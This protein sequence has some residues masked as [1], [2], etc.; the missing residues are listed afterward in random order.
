VDCRHSKWRSGPAQPTTLHRADAWQSSG[1]ISTEMKL[2]DGKFAYA[3]PAANLGE[4][5]F[6]DTPLSP[7][8]IKRESAAA[9]KWENQLRQGVRGSNE[10]GEA[11]FLPSR[12]SDPR[13]NS[14]HGGAKAPMPE[15]Q[16][17]ESQ[18]KESRKEDSQKRF[19]PHRFPRRP[20]VGITGKNSSGWWLRRIHQTES[21]LVSS[22]AH[23]AATAQ[24]DPVSFEPRSN[25][26][27]VLNCKL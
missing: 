23:P 8:T 13:I 10:S 4:I 17:E 21:K 25:E 22:S 6:D 11:R 16:N 5:T 1:L 20:R 24:I 14:D 19:T 12:G 2:S 27:C 18:N 26:V 7:R 15:S 3:S 9:K